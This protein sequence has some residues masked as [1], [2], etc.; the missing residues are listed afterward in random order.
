MNQVD[1]APA[2]GFSLLRWIGTAIF[3][4][5][6]VPLIWG[7]IRLV[8]LGGSPYYV[9]AGLLLAVTAILI[10]RRHA[11]ALW[12][13]AVILLGTIA[14]LG[15]ASPVYVPLPPVVVPPARVT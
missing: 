6:G 15:A 11:C 8:G 9:I 14:R 10:L 13:Y 1:S 4:V 3:L 12:L 7:G 5:L 2:E